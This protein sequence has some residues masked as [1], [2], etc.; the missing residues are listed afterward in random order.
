MV[1]WIKGFKSVNRLVVTASVDEIGW[2]YNGILYNKSV[3][4]SDFR[5]TLHAVCSAK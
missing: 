3:D 4:R 1:V 2:N 5:L